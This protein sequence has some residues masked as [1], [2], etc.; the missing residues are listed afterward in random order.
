MFWIV[1]H[2]CLSLNNASFSYCSKIYEVLVNIHVFAQIQKPKQIQSSNIYICIKNAARMQNYDN[3]H[4][5]SLPLLVNSQINLINN[6][7]FIILDFF[8]SYYQIFLSYL[9]IY[10]KCFRDGIHFFFAKAFL[11]DPFSQQLPN[12]NPLI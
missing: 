11:G 3:A 7:P 9:Q 12:T 6:Y 8:L 2:K 5:L 10:N 1:L 4:I